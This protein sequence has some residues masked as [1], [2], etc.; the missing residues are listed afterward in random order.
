MLIDFPRDASRG[1]RDSR[2]SVVRVDV[3]DSG[4]GIPPEALPH[5]F[6]KFYRVDN[7]DRREIKG[8]G[9][10]LAIAKQVV[11]THGGRIWA[12]SEGSGKGST[13]GFTLPTEDGLAT[14]E[15]TEGTRLPTPSGR[16]GDGTYVLAVDN[17]RAFGRWLAEVLSQEG[18]AARV[19]ASADEALAAIAAE[20]PA[21]LLLITRPA[22]P[23][24]TRSP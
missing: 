23:Q 2:R 8:T 10:G 15:E 12:E 17:D 19:A 20:R 9:L 4:V 1:L 6:G 22:T 7:S 21:V 18:Y 3:H 13:F 24:Q 14:S 11:E 16:V 5:L